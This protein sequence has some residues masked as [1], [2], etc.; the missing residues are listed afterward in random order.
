MGSSH[1]PNAL[2]RFVPIICRIRYTGIDEEVHQLQLEFLLLANI[3]HVEGNDIL[4]PDA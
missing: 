4:V 3:T 1:L 2:A